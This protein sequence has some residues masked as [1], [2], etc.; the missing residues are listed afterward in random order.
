M[1]ESNKAKVEINLSRV[2]ELPKEKS[3][4]VKD[5]LKIPTKVDQKSL[6]VKPTPKD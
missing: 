5:T 3:T 1:K 4:E 6:S 2:A